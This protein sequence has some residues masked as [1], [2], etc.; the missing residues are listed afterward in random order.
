MGAMAAAAVLLTSCEKVSPIGILVGGTSVDDRVAMSLE[1]YKDTYDSRLDV[2]EVQGEYSFLIGA[3]SHITTDPGRIDEMQ[4]IFLKHGDLFMAHL[5]DIADTKAEFYMTLTNSLLEGKKRYVRKFY[6]PVYSEDTD[7]LIALS[8]IDRLVSAGEIANTDDIDAF[9]F[10][11]LVSLL[12]RYG[13]K[14]VTED[15]I[16]YPFYPVVGNHDITHNGWALFTTIFRSSTYEFTVK[17][18]DGLYDR[19]IFL[20]SANGTLGKIQ[21]DTLEAGMF[22]HPDQKIRHTF[23]FTHTNIFR[24][25]SSEL[26]STFARE[27]LYYI[28]DKLSEWN[29]TM[30]FY[31]HV[32]QWDMRDFGGVTHVTLDSMC[33]ANCPEA[34]DYLVRITCHTDGT[35]ELD[36]VRMNYAIK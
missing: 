17:V 2:N 6:H 16:Q 11:D 22:D 25:A 20:D 27:E 10:A 21:V 26:A 30:V 28:L 8:D 35:V 9:L 24:P 32:H 31:G 5:G 3:D 1:V 19:F 23:A 34:G 7:L 33:E 12:D 18:G 36:R 29:T 4:Q 15:D 13:I 14:M